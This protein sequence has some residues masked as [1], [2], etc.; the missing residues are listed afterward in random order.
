MFEMMSVIGKTMSNDIFP[1]DLH[2]ESHGLGQYSVL[3][4]EHQHLDINPC[5]QKIPLN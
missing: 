4:E 3:S 1:F 2:R 5:R